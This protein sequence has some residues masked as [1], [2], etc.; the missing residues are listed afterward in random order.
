MATACSRQRWRKRRHYGAKSERTS[1]EDVHALEPGQ[2][3]KSGLTRKLDRE[4]RPAWQV[5][6]NITQYPHPIGLG[7]IDAMKQYQ[8]PSIAW[9]IDL[10]A[11]RRVNIRHRRWGNQSYRAQPVGGILASGKPIVITPYMSPIVMEP[12]AVPCTT[13]LLR[14][15]TPRG[16]WWEFRM[17]KGYK[18]RRSGSTALTS[19]NCRPTGPRSR[20]SCPTQ[21][22]K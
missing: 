12:L 22:A 17:W 15:A 14:H 18:Y 19:A 9:A 4:G 8:L 5:A 2:A 7:V 21:V 6:D 11:E 16:I 3:V 13:D 20:C 1:M 10:Q